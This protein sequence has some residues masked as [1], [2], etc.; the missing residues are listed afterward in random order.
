MFRHSLRQLRTVAFRKER[1]QAV[2]AFNSGAFAKTKFG[3]PSFQNYNLIPEISEYLR[4]KDVLTPSPVQQLVL[5]HFSDPSSKRPVFIGG[6]TGSGK[7]LAYLLPI[8]NSIKQFEKQHN[9]VGVIPNRPSV[10]VLCPSKELITQTHKVAKSISHYAKL[11]VEKVDTSGNWKLTRETVNEGLDVLVTNPNKLQRL[12]RE[13]R[14]TFSHLKYLV[15]DEADVFIES[16][17]AEYLT[18]LVKE[19]HLKRNSDEAAQLVFVSATLTPT[20]RIFLDSVFK[21]SMKYL[22][23]RDTHFNLA[24]LHHTFLPSHNDNKLEL[25]SSELKA[26]QKASSDFY[27]VVFCNSK[28]CVQAVHFWL[29]KEGF[30]C[31]ALHSDMP[32]RLRA[33]S[34]EQ[35]R[36]KKTNVLVCTD[37]GARG[38]DFPH[39][40]GVVNFDFPKNANDYI[41]RAGR[42]GRIGVKGVVVSFYKNQDLELIDQL[43]QSDHRH[44]PLELTKSSFA[45]MKTKRTEGSEVAR[46]GPKGASAVVPFGGGKGIGSGEG[47]RRGV[48]SIDKSARTKT[49]PNFV[50]RK[51]IQIKKSIK[52]EAKINENGKRVKFL[53]R[54]V[55]N[56]HKAELVRKG[57]LVLSDR[58]K[59]R[60]LAKKMK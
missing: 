17:E 47:R 29:K 41:H 55:K 46:R 24:N 1:A 6:P 44:I 37:V 43:K 58:I 30:N 34:F 16:G 3:L 49:K 19:V 15:V 20:L 60:L 8:L 52:K 53:R 35:F 13:H 14:V 42:A 21:E 25:L 12:A 54:T 45:L 32:I 9:Y 26:H 38:L 5:N 40:K 57:K 28:A 22:V 4:V 10:I 18:Q 2:S 11:K 27:F 31:S 23:T 39:L 48:R 7:T 50:R 36:D 33:E 59:R 56:M 51:I